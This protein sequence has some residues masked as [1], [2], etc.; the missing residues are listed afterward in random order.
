MPGSNTSLFQA[1]ALLAIV[2]LWPLL[3]FAD[4]SIFRISENWKLLLLWF[5]PMPDAALVSKNYYAPA[6]LIRR[7]MVL[8]SVPKS[9]NPFIS[10]KIAASNEDCSLGNF[11][12]P[13]LQHLKMFALKIFTFIIVAHKSRTLL[14]N[15]VSLAKPPTVSIVQILSVFLELWYKN[16]LV[17]YQFLYHNA[18]IGLSGG[19]KFVNIFGR[20]VWQPMKKGEFSHT[21]ALGLIHSYL[22]WDLISNFTSWLSFLTACC[23]SVKRSKQSHHLGSGYRQSVI[24]IY[25]K[26]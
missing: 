26:I 8:V 23:T 13:Q 18:F 5:W 7:V 2:L 12:S 22:F 20:Q 15:V 6:L 3:K 11:S 19:I 10:N 4:V 14:R 16:P 17:V 24:G 21:W 9:K 25:K 1:T